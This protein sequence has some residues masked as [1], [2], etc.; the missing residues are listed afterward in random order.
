MVSHMTAPTI[1]GLEQVRR[2]NMFTFGIN[3]PHCLP[4]IICP[5]RISI[6][7]SIWA[8]RWPKSPRKNNLLHENNKTTCDMEQIFLISIKL[9]EYDTTRNTYGYCRRMLFCHFKKAF[10]M[11]YN[12]PEFQQICADN[13]SNNNYNVWKKIRISNANTKG[14]LFESSYQPKR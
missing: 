11:Y 6:G 14:I 1:I 7:H 8:S 10:R 5:R 9:S 13:D 3:K 12:W 2:F 4:L